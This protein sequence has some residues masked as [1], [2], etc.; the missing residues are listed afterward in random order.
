MHIKLN[1]WFVN[2]LIIYAHC[3]TFADLPHTLVG[4][5][6]E[7]FSRENHEARTDSVKNENICSERN[8]YFSLFLLLVC[9]VWWHQMSAYLCKWGG[10]VCKDPGVFSATMLC[11]KEPICSVGR[12]CQMHRTES[13]QGYGKGLKMHA[14]LTRFSI[15]HYFPIRFMADSYHFKMHGVLIVLLKFV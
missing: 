15:C 6:D 10:T 9:F 12:E 4:V 14:T 2:S 1:I 5:S 7:F 13:S 11:L 8:A 3:A